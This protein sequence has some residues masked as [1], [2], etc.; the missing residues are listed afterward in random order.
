[1]MSGRLREAGHYVE[2]RAI[3]VNE[4]VSWQGVHTRYEGM[5]ASGSLPR[6]TVRQAHDAGVSGDWPI[7]CRSE[8]GAV[9]SSTGRRRIRVKTGHKGFRTAEGPDRAAPGHPPCRLNIS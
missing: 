8:P 4:R 2:A 7:V 9:K 1:M 6:F 3:A 5:T